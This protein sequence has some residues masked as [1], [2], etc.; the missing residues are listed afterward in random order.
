MSLSSFLMNGHRVDLYI[1][2]DVRGVPTGVTLCDA[3]RILPASAIFQYSQHKS[4]AGFANFFRYKLLLERGGWWV[5]ADIVCLQP[6]RFHDDHVI[7]TEW[8]QLRQPVITNAPLK[9][10]RNSPAMQYAWQV[11]E[12]KDT[13]KIVWGE[14]GPRLMAEAVRTYSLDRFVARPEAFCPIP[15]FEWKDVLDPAHEWTFGPETSAIHLWNEMWRRNG[16]DKDAQYDPACLYEQL[17]AR[18]SQPY[19]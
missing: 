8:T 12:R 1:Y 7:P 9:A 15:W 19:R 6:F 13:Q 2:E 17:K 4:Y 18:F 10:P 14:T 11:C 3:N 5:D 16:Q